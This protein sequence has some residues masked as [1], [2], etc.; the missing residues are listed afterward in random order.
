MFGALGAGGVI[1]VGGTMPPFLWVPGVGA[2]G[3]GFGD[4]GVL[5]I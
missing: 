5:F 1:V 3:L 2:E 4:A